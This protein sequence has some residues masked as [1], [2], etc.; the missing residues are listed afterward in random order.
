MKLKNKAHFLVSKKSQII[1]FQSEK[2]F[3]P[4]E[5]FPTARFLQSSQNMKKSTFP[6]STF[7]QN[8]DPFPRFQGKINP[9]QND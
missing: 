8:G 9:G 3:T 6:G 5:H 7:S 1:L 2:I 4:I